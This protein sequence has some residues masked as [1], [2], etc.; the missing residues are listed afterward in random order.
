[1]GNRHVSPGDKVTYPVCPPAS[2]KHINQPPLGPI[3]A[4]VLRPRRLGHPQRLD[5]QPRARRHG[6]AL[7]VRQGRVRRRDARA[8]ARA[9]HEPAT[10]PRVSDPTRGART[11]GRA[12]RADADQVR[13]PRLGP[14]AVHGRAGHRQDDRVLQPLLGT[15]RQQRRVPGAARAAVHAAVAEP[16]RGREPGR[17]GRREREPGRVRGGEPERAGGEPEAPA[18]SPSAPA[19]SPSAEPSPSAS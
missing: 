2:G 17:V 12:L 11:R 18:A 14:G 6:G 1:M 8:A 9:R 3:P 13:G 15:P 7:L 19:A 4:Q 5:P 16:V 10:E